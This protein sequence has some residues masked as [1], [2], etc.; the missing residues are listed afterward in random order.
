MAG[1]LPV[2]L[3]SSPLTIQI[4][5]RCS[6]ILRNR[7]LDFFIVL[8][9]F[10]SI[11]PDVSNVS[12]LRTLRVLRAL[13]TLTFAEGLKN[14]L[15]TIVAALPSLVNVGVLL[16]FTLF[17]IGMIAIELWGGVLKG[18]CAYLDPDS[19]GWVF[20]DQQCALSCDT[21]GLANVTAADADAVA[22][23]AAG[24][25]TPAYGDSCPSSY[26]V[27]QTDPV[28]GN[29]TSVV[30]AAMTCMR[31]ENPDWGM[32][33][34][35][36]I[37]SAVLTG[38]VILTTEGWSDTMYRVWH[39]WG[40]PVFV[41]FIMVVFMLFGS[42]F[43]LNLAL[44]AI[45]EEYDRVSALEKRKNDK[46]LSL[47]DSQNIR[48]SDIVL[49][50]GEG[51]LADLAL[52]LSRLQ[53]AQTLERRR[54]SDRIAALRSV[55]KQES[56]GMLDIG[57]GIGAAV[58]GL[59]NIAEGVGH[60]VAHAAQAV[61]GFVQQSLSRPSSFL[62]S[63]TQH[64]H[65]SR[66]ASMTSIT[67]AHPSR[68][69]SLQTMLPTIASP[70]GGES[71][72]S[73]TSPDEKV[74]SVRVLDAGATTVAV[75]A[76]TGG[77]SKHDDAS[78]AVVVPASPALPAADAAAPN[79]A[80]QLPSS[81][82]SAALSG[83]DADASSRMVAS[84]DTSK[85]EDSLVDVAD[86][87]VGDD[88]DG[89][90]DSGGGAAAAAVGGGGGAAAVSDGVGLQRTGSAEQ[91]QQIG[92]QAS[93]SQRAAAAKAAMASFYR[94]YVPAPPFWVRMPCVRI[95]SHW[96]FNTFM[97][98]C[99][100]GN[101]LSLACQYDGN[102]PNNGMDADYANGLANA[103]IVFVVIFACEMTFKLLGLGLKRY[104]RDS[105]NVFD[106]VV[107]LV[108]ILELILNAVA[109]DAFGGGISALRTFRMFRVLK[110]ARS[111]K[112]L[113]SL[114]STVI[115]IIPAVANASLILGVVMFIFSLL[116]MQ[117]FGGS[118]D[119]AVSAGILDEV[120]R[121]NFNNLWWSWVTV[122][123]VMT[124]E[125]WNDVL[126]QHMASNGTA[127]FLYFVA[128]VV[129]GNYIF[130]NLFLA[131][132]L[133]GFEDAQKEVEEKL[134][135]H[136][137]G[138]TAA[139]GGAASKLKQAPALLI[140][141]R[142]AAANALG[143]AAFEVDV[144]TFIAQASSSASSEP[145]WDLLSSNL[146]RVARHMR[147]V[148][149]G[150][151]PGNCQICNFCENEWLDGY[152]SEEQG[153]AGNSEA[154]AASG[155]IDG[156][157]GAGA[158]L[159]AF[160]TGDPKGGD[161]DSA[162][163][164]FQNPLSKVSPRDQQQPLH[165]PR[166]QQQQH[167][168]MG[169][170]TAQLQQVVNPMRT[171]SVGSP[172]IADPRSTGFAALAS[173]ASGR[174]SSG[175]S[176]T[177]AGGATAAPAAPSLAIPT[178]TSPIA[179]SPAG[180]SASAAS[181]SLSASKALTRPKS[182]YAAARM[183]RSA[184]AASMSRRHALDS[185]SLD[186][187]SDFVTAR[188]GGS[189][190]GAVSPDAS[191]L[192][193]TRQDGPAPTT[194]RSD[195]IQRGNSMAGIVTMVP[196]TPSVGRGLH[197]TSPTGSAASSSSST[198]AAPPTPSLRIHILKSG[199]VRVIPVT[200]DTLP[201][202][203]IFARA[204]EMKETHNSLAARGRGK[205]ARVVNRIRSSSAISAAA[206]KVGMKSF[207]H[208]S[209]S[210]RALSTGNGDG[211]GNGF[212]ND[213]IDLTEVEESG[214]SPDA[215]SAAAHI[216]AF[217]VVG[218]FDAKRAVNRQVSDPKS[219]RSRSAP[220]SVLSQTGRSPTP[221]QTGVSG[222]SRASPPPG[223]VASSASTP[224]P[225]PPV[226]AGQLSKLQQRRQQRL[227]DKH[228]GNPLHEPSH[229]DLKETYAA[230]G[231]LDQLEAEPTFT[232]R[233]LRMEM[234]QHNSCGFIPNHSKF[235]R[236]CARI[237]VHPWFER[238]TM[239]V[240]LLS[241]INLALDEPRID[242]CKDL[243][244]SDSQSCA[245]L[246][247]YLDGADIAITAYFCAEIVLKLIAQ[248][249][250][251]HELAYLRSGWNVLDF[252]VVTVSIVSLAIAN[253]GV[254]ALR[255]FRAL[256]ALRPL[257]AVSRF[258][259]LKLVVNSL[260]RSLPKVLDLALVTFLFIFIFAVI[261]NQNFGGILAGCND[262]SIDNAAACV[263]TWTLVGD[264][265]SLLPNDFAEAS[266]RNST[267]YPSFPRIWSSLPR[268]YDNIG[269]S[270]L[271]V[272]ELATGED[273]PS[274]MTEASDGAASPGQPMIR[275]T[276]Q[277]AAIYFIVIQVVLGF[278]ML[279]FFAGIIV[280]TYDSL[281]ANSQGVGLL[282]PAQVVWVD[283][284][285]MMLAVGP[286]PALR[287][288]PDAY[289]IIHDESN[290]S[291]SDGGSSSRLLRMMAGTSRN[292]SPST[293][294][295][296]LTVAAAVA[297]T[298][299]GGAA[300]S[301]SHGAG[302]RAPTSSPEATP[303]AVGA[304]SAAALL[305][306]AAAAAA[307]A[308]VGEGAQPSLAARSWASLRMA[309]WRC[310]NNK[311][312]EI[313]IMAAILINVVF[314]ALKHD[315]M[316]LQLQKVIENA[317][318]AFTIVFVIE[319]CIKLLGLGPKQYFDS[320]WCRFDFVLAVA[321][322]CSSAI[323]INASLTDGAK[324]PG[325]TIATLLRIL[326]ILR[327]FRLIKTSKGL[328]RMLRTVILALPS[329]SNVAGVLFLFYFMFSVLG[330]NVLSGIRYNSGFSNVVGTGN[331]NADANFDSF[332]IALITLF[333][334]ST[335][336]N[337]NGI[338]HDLMVAAPYCNVAADGVLDPNTGVPIDN[339]GAGTIIPSIFFTIFFSLTDFLMLKLLVAIILDA[340]L[341]SQDL[342]DRSDAAAYTL[343]EPTAKRFRKAW[344]VLDPTATRFINYR[345]LITLV[346]G[347]DHPLGIANH[348]RHKPEHRNDPVFLRRAAERVVSKLNLV[349]DRRGRFQYYAVLHALCANA[350]GGSALGAPLGAVSVIGG[351]SGTHG[352]TLREIR[353][354]I[355][356]QSAFRNMRLRKLRE[357]MRREHE[358]EAA[359]LA[360]RKVV[361]TTS[362]L[363][364]FAAGVRR[365]SVSAAPAAAPP[366]PTTVVGFAP[367]PPL[368]TTGSATTSAPAAANAAHGTTSSSSVLRSKFGAGLLASVIASSK[369]SGDDGRAPTASQGAG[370]EL[371]DVAAPSALPPPPPLPAGAP[372]AP[373]ASASSVPLPPP[374][375][376][377]AAAPT[378][379]PPPQAGA[380]MRVVSPLHA[381]GLGGSCRIGGAATTLAT[382]GSNSKEEWNADGGKESVEREANEEEGV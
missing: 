163:L 341:V 328:Q 32:T 344:Q 16:L 309:C 365:L 11:S 367:A 144:D 74:G 29:V 360:M 77:E 192:L 83:V 279:D 317:N 52:Q 177:N 306:Q 175:L 58:S 46:L 206:L 31:G 136:A 200:I 90:H 329:L 171:N 12:A 311:W 130:L 308:A 6:R 176:F 188:G 37:G 18:K 358:R 355:L 310:T 249:L 371:T 30:S 227:K 293:S 295:R 39:S 49:A 223:S 325:G 331:F 27:Y 297:D 132:L 71:D 126:H 5:L 210:A 198:L 379:L 324:V 357:A 382:G 221:P 197:A 351:E 241:S 127:S 93:I 274:R 212:D 135:Q 372:P 224:S 101:S 376:V 215:A 61:D 276:D 271:T 189:A 151:C 267:G 82:S 56:V 17:L 41:S 164:S 342:E 76:N 240:I 287:P 43:L 232:M 3:P 68:P 229:D 356:V 42:F 258:P 20:I 247:H 91:L 161:G 25:C 179:L 269:N 139:V 66:P 62:V 319:A 346:A 250:Y 116:G 337:Y 7:R 238:L 307:A 147:D 333:R 150:R 270:M 248:G 59:G 103:N 209:N 370:I 266:C 155:S 45:N 216:D 60:A 280:D 47:L 183:S 322:V 84:V 320:K 332:G 268:N 97:V 67:S 85:V 92:R 53:A 121:A 338:M 292:N 117:L 23:A 184:T 336:E 265:C 168:A 14:I 235:R 359:M 109:P 243:P 289:G 148:C 226:V 172:S 28:F 8:M 348:P 149:V 141:D 158:H 363:S 159:G 203:D 345:D 261:G 120:P 195:F 349:P 38:Y 44:A 146:R 181:A 182:K 230:T 374:P 194:S 133:N 364:T 217:T 354:A 214:I 124:N 54:E 375:P 321:A 231:M 118:Y 142:P 257:R 213:G 199:D 302:H 273:W 86:E 239:L 89:G 33:N 36:N 96:A 202:D 234:D 254:K 75:S 65:P 340:F 262:P 153:E 246:S 40:E 131:I 334:C 316:T 114:I 211:L 95:T 104:V 10:I 157:G 299:P 204:S 138:A 218:N 9:C 350:S 72:G 169:S 193:G 277:A 112:Q 70:T 285:R 165:S 50:S 294:G 78:A 167:Q 237:V 225:P 377:P 51:S 1:L 323:S 380:V 57:A 264:A 368:G 288:P 208:Q 156:A 122:F 170:P 339:C 19:N 318:Y 55:A 196:S 347:L 272:Y 252:A 21:S 187:S 284:M 186:L 24:L 263:G 256:R 220:S 174:F 253:S 343:T 245:T 335:G 115:S 108:S 173:P 313:T 330:M 123:W 366:Q 48:A 98:C 143:T 154:T 102:T 315:E 260:L 219:S 35:D 105:F 166:Q 275:D 305:P 137:S 152:D 128:L 242:G 111:W 373:S 64:Q 125:N 140:A 222:A 99:I 362:V 290:D 129:I 314:L 81:S 353:A 26:F 244:A 191:A 281:K 282:T 87:T 326:R 134:D 34:F 201:S 80:L 88:D 304:K 251:F 79:V 352:F 13:R 207:A 291:G 259:G 378:V 4:D 63:S 162:S 145:P 303:I 278:I 180:A 369:S 107:V 22:A 301:S 283:N 69:P 296:S 15:A 300:S 228:R 327:L 381:A 255:A 298:Q 178:V 100:I 160:L 110:L 106:G 2:P 190:R 233:A 94:K 312:F 119:A 361:V 286:K 236:I 113:N 205:L 73:S 185:D